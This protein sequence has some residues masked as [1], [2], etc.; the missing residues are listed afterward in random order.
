MW[1]SYTT[2][3][4]LPIT[5]RVQLVNLKKFVIA[6]LDADSETIV[7]YVAIQE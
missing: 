5:K 2:N 7:M 6:A 3:K 4:V 1:K